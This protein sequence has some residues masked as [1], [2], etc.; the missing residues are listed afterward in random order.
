MSRCYTLFL[1]S[2][3]YLLE[4]KKICIS[5]HDLYFHFTNIVQQDDEVEISLPRDFDAITVDERRRR[6][7]LENGIVFVFL[8]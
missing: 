1:L 8:T 3:A 6:R 7:G 4:I 5:F 2:I